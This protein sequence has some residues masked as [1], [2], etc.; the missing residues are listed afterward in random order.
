MAGAQPGRLARSATGGGAAGAQEGGPEGASSPAPG[1]APA[2][3]AR[4]E[5]AALQAV[6]AARMWGKGDGE[7]AERER[8]RPVV[9]ALRPSP[10][11]PSPACAERYPGASPL[12]SQSRRRRRR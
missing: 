10:A 6:G 1:P 4:E 3:A 8:R 12:S 5:L 9:D 11:Q 7:A 2:P